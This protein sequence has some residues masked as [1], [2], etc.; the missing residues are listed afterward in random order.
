MT[1]Y[2][3]YEWRYERFIRV[4]RSNHISHAMFKANILDCSTHDYSF[5]KEIP[6]S[7]IKKLI[8][9][10][11]WEYYG[12]IVLNSPKDDVIGY[13]VKELKKIGSR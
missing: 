4:R 13:L 2:Y 10:F 1:Y 7:C 3:V 6:E 12:S 11:Q 8:P 9:N 5:I